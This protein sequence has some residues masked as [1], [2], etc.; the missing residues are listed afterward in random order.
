LS[1]VDSLS[2]LIDY[3]GL[4]YGEAVVVKNHLQKQVL[5]LNAQVSSYRDEGEKYIPS[6][7][8]CGSPGLGRSPKVNESRNSSVRKTHR[9]SEGKLRKLV[10][11]A[12]IKKTSR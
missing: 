11:K 7:H 10:R 1:L 4:S 8:K 3:Y 6:G 5:R 2:S 9:V 12:L